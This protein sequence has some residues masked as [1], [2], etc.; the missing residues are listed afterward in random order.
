MRPHQEP[1]GLRAT[2]QEPLTLGEDANF[3]V[4]S[5]PAAALEAPLVFAGYGLKIPERQIDD[6]AD[7]DRRAIC[8]YF[9]TL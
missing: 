8:H 2:F 6:F 9:I 4:R 5:E 1:F 3:S 7:Q